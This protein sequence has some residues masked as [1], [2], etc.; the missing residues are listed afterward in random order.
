MGLSGAPGMVGTPVPVGTRDWQQVIN[1]LPKSVLMPTDKHVARLMAQFSD[2][3][4]TRIFPG[5]KLLARCMGVSSRTVIRSLEVLRDAGLLILVR[6]GNTR[7]DADEYRLSVPQNIVELLALPDALAPNLH[8]NSC[9][10]AR[11]SLGAYVTSVSP[12]G[13][14]E[15]RECACG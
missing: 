11:V 13:V 4:G 15:T 9:P 14:M 1:R 6:H 2:P 10:A 7:G 8:V 3:D 12:A 5:V